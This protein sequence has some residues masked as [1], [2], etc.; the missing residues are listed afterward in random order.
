MISSP[1]KLEHLVGRDVIDEKS[2]KSSKSQRR[3]GIIRG[4]SRQEDS[5][6]P[7]DEMNISAV[8]AA[9]DGNREV[10]SII[11]DSCLAHVFSYLPNFDLA[12]VIPSICQFFF[13]ICNEYD[14]VLWR[15][16]CRDLWRDKVWVQ[17]TP[18]LE[19]PI[20]HDFDYETCIEKARLEIKSLE[21]SFGMERTHELN[22]RNMYDFSVKASKTFILKKEALSSKVWAF[23]F[24]AAAGEDW[25]QIDPYWQW[26]NNYALGNNHTMYD[27]R[28]NNLI[29][30]LR[31]F[32]LNGTITLP[33]QTAPSNQSQPMLP[34]KKLQQTLQ[35]DRIEQ[36]LE[37][38][39]IRQPLFY[40]VHNTRRGIETGTVL[41]GEG[42]QFVKVRNWPSVGIDRTDN[43]GWVMQNQW[44]AYVFPPDILIDLH[45]ELERDVERWL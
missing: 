14:N 18:S 26:F 22:F 35:P 5:I 33:R 6:I 39:G 31:Q 45:E 12:V 24:K 15:P 17:C 37:L 13:R 30:T 28:T 38:M 41:R 19:F 25:M 43:W 23:R 10:L 29:Y 8:T 7:Y 44:V 3:E 1:F 2:M 34:W 42:L 9:R 20:R 16:R 11:P 36:E 27:D 40:K 4:L 21:T 32:N